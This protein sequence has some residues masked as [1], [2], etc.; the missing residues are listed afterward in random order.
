MGYRY[1]AV[2]GMVPLKTPQINGV[3][4]AIRDALP[5]QAQLHI[6]GFAKADDID[7]FSSLRITSF[8]TTSPLLRA[9]KDKKCNYYLPGRNG[10][11]AS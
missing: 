1:L 3:I 4:S 6:L 5:A 8:D 2:G 9:F 7:S 10:G 11:T